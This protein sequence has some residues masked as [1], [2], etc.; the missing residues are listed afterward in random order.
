VSKRTEVAAQ[1]IGQVRAKQ[2]GEAAA[3]LAENV[4]LTVPGI[5]PIEGRGG[6]EAA[7]RMASESGRGLERVGWSAPR[8]ENGTVVLAGKAP[9]GLLGVV[10]KLLKKQ[11]AVTISC[12]FTDDNIAKLDIV[13]A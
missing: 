5:G 11:V 7:L 8:E 12:A 9:P 3:M 10:A 4:V 1:F 2:F 13:T 6:V